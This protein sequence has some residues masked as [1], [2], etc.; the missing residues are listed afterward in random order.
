MNEQQWRQER[1]DRTIRYA[2][3]R[4]N[5]DRCIAITASFPYIWRY[6]GQIAILTAA[7]LLSRMSPSI[8][9]AF[10]D[11]PVHSALPWAGR[12]L[13]EIILSQMRAAD[14]YGRFQARSFQA[15]DYRFHLGPNGNNFV[16]HGLG[17]NA[18]LGPSPSPLLDIDD[19]NPFGAAFA[20]IVAV[21]QVFVHDFE[22]P[23]DPF[24]ANT[25]TWEHD[26]ASSAPALSQDHLGNIWV[27]GAGSV[28]TAALYFLSL[29]T[30]RF[31][32]VLID[33][34]RIKRQNLDRSPIFTDNDVGR[35]KV[36][37]TR[38]FLQD[39]GISNVQTEICALHESELWSGRPA[40]TPDLLIAAANEQNVR[41]HVEAQYPPIQLYGTTGGSWQASLIRHIPG[42]EPCSCCLFPD[43]ISHAAL[44]CGSASVQSDFNGTEQIDAALPFL[45]FAAGLMTATEI[46]KLSLPGYP[47]NINRVF[48]YTR[49][50]PRLVPAR[51]SRDK[52]CICGKRSNQLHQK[53]L[54]GS[55]YEHLTTTPIPV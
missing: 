34:D 15:S 23:N 17:W 43:E 53:M 12:S 24:L 55:K 48:L 52:N 51:I 18:Y 4:L 45:S 28:G 3:R 13:H 35:Y 50:H 54:K 9:L 7:N 25:L 33:M 42:I 14:P 27:V 44:A 38:D 20:V 8:I 10:P 16:I 32:A 11:V 22:T 40:G 39:I 30:R 26:Q 19:G 47:F 2:A 41:Y 6:D 31:S 1:D 5:P 49:P 36:E 21:S 46:F 29:I 37:A